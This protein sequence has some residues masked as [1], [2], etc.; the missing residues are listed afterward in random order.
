MTSTLLMTPDMMRVLKESIVHD[1]SL[2]L[3]YS[4][5]R[6]IPTNRLPKVPKTCKLPRSDAWSDEFTARWNS[7]ACA[8]FGEVDMA[9]LVDDSVLG[10]LR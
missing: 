3:I 4:G 5:M 1:D 6:V 9:L 2:G 7:W 8:M 10:Y